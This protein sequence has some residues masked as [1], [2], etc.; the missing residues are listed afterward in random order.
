M[1]YRPGRLSAVSGAAREGAEPVMEL[2]SS[3]AYR[4]IAGEMF[5]VDSQKALLHEL[6][7]PAALIW[8]G[9]AAGKTEKALLS[10]LTAEFEVDETTARADLRDFVKELLRSGLLTPGPV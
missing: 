2:K 1:N 6:N 4:R 3:L 8:E 5:I 9:L 10:A 7:G